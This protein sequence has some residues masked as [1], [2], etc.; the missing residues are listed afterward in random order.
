[1]KNL[2]SVYQRCVLL[3]L[4]GTA[5][6]LSIGNLSPSFL[7]YPW[8]L[9]IAANYLYLLVMMYIFSDRW[10]WVKTLYHREACLS[11]LSS[12]LILTLLFGLIPQ[13][14]TVGGVIGALGFSNMATSWIF[15]VFLLYFMTVMGMRVIDD[16]YHWKKR[17]KLVLTIHAAFFVILVAGIFGSGD[18]M[19]IKVVTTLGQPVQGGMTSEGKGVN[20]PFSILLKEFSMEEYPPRIYRL[21]QG[22]LSKAFLT[23]EA[24]DTEATLEDWHIECMEYLDRAGRTG[25]EAKYVSMNHVGATTAIRVKAT[26]PA[27]GKSVEGWISCGSHIFEGSTLMLPDGSELVMPAREPK[28]FLSSIEVANEDGVHSLEVM[29]NHPA[30]VGGWKIYQVG[31]DNAHG[32]WSTTSVLECVKDAWYPA[33]H[34]SMWTLLFSGVLMFIF[35]WKKPERRKEEEL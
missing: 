12:L 29:V 1:M 3:L 14:K 24:S 19:R 6:Q 34:L 18:K 32:K 33:I 17:N 31:Y 4:A 11:S 9:L 8:G 13:E 7:S 35:G 2:Y 5:L 28:K 23:I 22:T 16:L 10:K 21:Q 15:I 25:E 27:T 30:T 20:L 26:H